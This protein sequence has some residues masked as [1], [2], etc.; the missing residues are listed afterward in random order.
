MNSLDANSD[1]LIMG[2]LNVTPDS[3]SDG[4]Q[5]L[6]PDIA[7]AH[8]RQMVEEGASIIDIGAESEF[9]KLP[10]PVEVGGSSYFLI[11]GRD[12]YKLLSTLCPH[13]G[14]TIDDEGGE[15]VCNG[16]GYQYDTDGGRCI[17]NPDLRMK[18]YPV[19]VKGGRLI[20]LA[21]D[22]T[23]AATPQSGQTVQQIQHPPP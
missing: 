1:P 4:G 13:Q 16:H 19:S 6:K 22:E 14:G 18:L 11:K 10:A 7:I 20:A 12:G 5:F 9:T 21:P 23:E 2:V 8:A 3:F 15:F 17:T